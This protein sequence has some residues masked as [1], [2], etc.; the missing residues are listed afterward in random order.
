MV[1]AYELE[2]ARI[3][4]VERHQL[5]KLECTFYPMTAQAFLVTL[6]RAMYQNNWHLDGEKHI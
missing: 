3:H 5:P 4:Q 6:S 1:T 2:A